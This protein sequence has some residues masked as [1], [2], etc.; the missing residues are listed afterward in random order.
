MNN[1]FLQ[2]MEK[3]CKSCGFEHPYLTECID[4]YC[5]VCHSVVSP[6]AYVG[7]LFCKIPI[8]KQPLLDLCSV[9]CDYCMVPFQEWV[10]KH[11][12]I[13]KKYKMAYYESP[14]DHLR[15]PEV[16]DVRSDL[17]GRTGHIAW[18]V[19]SGKSV[20]GWPGF[21]AGKGKWIKPCGQFETTE[22]VTRETYASVLESLLQ[23]NG[24]NLYKEIQVP[25]LSDVP[26]IYKLYELEKNMC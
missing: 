26:G 22:N 18:F 6:E 21:Y 9:C 1:R 2:E 20:L 11:T 5:Y 16:Y 13:G 24:I 7:C 25:C 4:G 10:K 8:L 15:L 3:I 23:R 14:P 12:N 17:M 19:L